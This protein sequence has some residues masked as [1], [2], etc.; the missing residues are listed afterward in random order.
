VLVAHA[1][2]L[3]TS[4]LVDSAA[5]ASV[6]GPRALGATKAACVERLHGEASSAD[7]LSAAEPEGSEKDAALEVITFHLRAT[8]A[9][10]ARFAAP[11][12]R[13]ACTSWWRPQ[14]IRSVATAQG[15]P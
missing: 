10:V 15:P 8:H 4:S 11:S 1:H 13:I 9:P 12:Q 14:P 5:N 7:E 2:A 6:A 3:G